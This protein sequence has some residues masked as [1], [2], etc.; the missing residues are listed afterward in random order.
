[1]QNVIST[2]VTAICGAM[3]A[4]AAVIVMTNAGLMPVNEVQLRR[5]SKRPRAPRPTRR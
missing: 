3:I 2:L 5:K 4:V 1:M